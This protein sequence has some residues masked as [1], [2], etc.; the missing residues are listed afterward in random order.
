[1][2]VVTVFGMNWNVP[3]PGWGEQES[4]IN[5]LEQTM[6]ER[7]IIGQAT[8]ILMERYNITVSQAAGFLTRASQASGLPLSTVALDVVETGEISL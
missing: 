7:E 2:Q 6:A 5:R 4:K 8:G 1:M 3:G